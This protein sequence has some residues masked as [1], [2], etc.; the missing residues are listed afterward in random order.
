MKKN[1]I[2]NMVAKTLQQLA[3][4]KTAQRVKADR[5]QLEVNELMNKPDNFTFL[6]YKKLCGEG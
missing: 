3:G 2:G 6:R 5:L 4:Q 1:R